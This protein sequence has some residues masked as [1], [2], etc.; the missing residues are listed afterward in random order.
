MAKRGI[1][2]ESKL[3][4]DASNRRRPEHAARVL[5]LPRLHLQAVRLEDDQGAASEV[6]SG[7]GP[8]LHLC[9]KY[10]ARCTSTGS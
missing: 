5:H 9:Q 2:N 4:A 10:V 1:V 6:S 3:S 8:A 7:L